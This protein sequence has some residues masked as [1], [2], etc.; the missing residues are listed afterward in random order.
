MKRQFC[1]PTRKRFKKLQE[2]F[3][4]WLSR[5]R[6][7]LVSMRKQVRCLAS[8]GGQGSGVAMSWAA[9]HR[10]GSDLALLRL[11]RRLAPAA[12]IRPRAWE[13]PNVT[14]TVLKR[15]KKKKKERKEQ[16]ITGMTILSSKGN[17]GSV[18]TAKSLSQIRTLGKHCS[19][20]NKTWNCL[21]LKKN[22]SSQEPPQQMEPTGGHSAWACF[23]PPSRSLPFSSLFPNHWLPE[24]KPIPSWTEVLFQTQVIWGTGHCGAVLWP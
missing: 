13:L 5:L 22:E 23:S 18:V 1:E 7:R 12:P 24:Y 11:W 20:K 9:S 21:A 14:G 6:T 17:V 8:F 3:L 15:Q 16:E 4:L 2:E 10:H 19:L